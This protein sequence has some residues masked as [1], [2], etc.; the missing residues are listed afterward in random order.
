MEGGIGVLAGR[1]P[2]SK[3]RGREGKRLMT[4]GEIGGTFD[5]LPG[6]FVGTGGREGRPSSSSSIEGNA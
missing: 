2:G 4:E 6:I 1:G 5:E 3:S